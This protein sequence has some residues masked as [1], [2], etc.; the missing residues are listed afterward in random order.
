MRT[1]WSR[2]L[3][4]PHLS[5]L[6][7]RGTEQRERGKC[8]TT[9]LRSVSLL[10]V[11]HGTFTEHFFLP[12]PRP[13]PCSLAAGAVKVPSGNRPPPRHAV[14]LR[15]RRGAHSD[16]DSAPR[17]LA[18]ARA[19]NGVPS[20]GSRGPLVRSLRASD[21]RDKAPTLELSLIHISEPTRLLSI[22][23]AVFCL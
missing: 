12:D 10:H 16:G 4:H 11:S 23:Y 8:T 7:P 18:A 17:S 14:P 3:W 15:Q 6:R 5:G 2:L 1:R 19:S 13:C 9:S 22:S 21:F 20:R